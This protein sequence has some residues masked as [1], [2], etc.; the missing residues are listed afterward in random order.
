MSLLSKIDGPARLAVRF[1]LYPLSWMAI[2]AGSYAVW[3]TDADPRVI[4]STVSGSLLALYLVI[5][6]ALPYQKRWSMTWH[7]FLADLKFI[8]INALVGGLL[9]IALGALAITIAGE[10]SGPARSWHPAIQLAVAL[11]TFEAINYTLHRTMHEAPGKLGN[12]LWR[13]HAAHHLPP[14][15]YLVM[16][17]VF[18]PINAVMIRLLAT[19][20]PIWLLGFEPKVIAMFAMI[21][22]VHGA[23]SH[24]NVDVRAG[25]MNYLFVG[26]ELHRYHHSADMNECKN[27]GAVLSVYDLLFGTFVYRPGV[28]PKEL[29]VDP[30]LG[31]PPYESTWK[32]LSLPFVRS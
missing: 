27:Y 18:H 9:S 29:G 20:L 4:A 8:A 21:S 12:F 16:H 2:L 32:V 26:T 11:L 6:L 31:L 14:R 3:T 24:F 28:P 13:M 15:L 23:I 25:W 19:I 5:E 10:L 1:G 30:A 22:G 7:S 17:G